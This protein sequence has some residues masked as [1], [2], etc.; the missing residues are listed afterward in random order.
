MRKLRLSFLIIFFITIGSCSKIESDPNPD[1]Q[2]DQN[3]TDYNGTGYVSELNNIGAMV[4]F[5]IDVETSKSYDMDVR[6]KT[7]SEFKDATVTLYV[8]DVMIQNLT[9]PMSKNFRTINVTV[10]LTS[11]SNYIVLKTET[12]DNGEYCLD[13]IELK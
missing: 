13:Y 12:S 5:A 1:S 2:D 11:G 3:L 8:N 9:L 4:M 10:P 6:Y 7:N